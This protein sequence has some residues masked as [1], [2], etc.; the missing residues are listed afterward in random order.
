MVTFDLWGLESQP[1]G[2][3]RPINLE[4]LLLMFRLMGTFSEHL[5][6]AATVQVSLRS[7]CSHPFPH[8]PEVSEFDA[9]G[10]W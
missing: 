2:P 9:T 6:C 1:L 8:H 4:S 10:K 3:H 7:H 5:L